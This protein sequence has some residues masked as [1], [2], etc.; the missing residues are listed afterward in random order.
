MIYSIVL[1]GLLFLVTGCSSSPT[2]IHTLVPDIYIDSTRSVA[3]RPARPFDGRYRGKII[4][5]L[6]HLD[7]PKDEI[8]SEQKLRDIVEAFHGVNVSHILIGPVPNEGHILSRLS[9]PTLGRRIRKALKTMDSNRVHLYCG[10]DYT[11]NWLEKAYKHGYEKSEFNEVIN[12]LAR[13]L[14]DSDCIGMGEIGMYHFNKTGN[15]HVLEYAPTF[16]PFLEIIGRIAAKGKWVNLHIEPVTPEGESY[17]NSAFGGVAMLFKQNPDLKLILSHT[18]MTSPANLKRLFQRYP[19][20]MV[21]FKPIKKHH[22]WKNL[23]PITN[24]R[25]QLYDDWANLFEAMS[26]RFLVGSD[27][28]F[29]RYG[30]SHDQANYDKRIKQIRR[31]LGSI[32]PEAAEQI[33]YK[34]AIRIFGNR[35]D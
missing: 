18:A 8:I 14:D 24:S 1:T 9:D 32:N 26:E 28:K 5:A 7:P 25:G 11:S 4:D 3:N 16:K 13:D 2:N 17:E 30:D 15:Q 23:E 27:A 35:L 33:A 34:N 19:N 10:S 6:T 31:I 20:L 12:K 22:K 21:T 29:G